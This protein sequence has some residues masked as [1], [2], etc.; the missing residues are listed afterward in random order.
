MVGKIATETELYQP[1]HDFMTALGYEVHGEV[2]GCDLTA[3][4]EGELVIIELK[5]SINLDLLIQ[6][7]KRQ[8]LTDE[9]YIAVPKPKRSPFSKYW[10]DRC[11]LVRRL[12][13][14]LITV[15][16]R[17]E[18]PQVEVE[19]F[20]A[21]FNRQ[22]SKQASKRKL[23]SLKTELEGRH[24]NF[25]LGGSSRKKLMTA[26]KEN[27][28]HIA[29]CLQKYGTLSPKELRTL[30]TGPKTASIL[31]KNFYHWFD[32]VAYG[33]YQLSTE[34]EAAL[35][36]FSQLAIYYDGLLNKQDFETSRPEELVAKTDSSG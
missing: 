9:V 10:K 2:Q 12:E 5:R 6:A 4:K 33:S 18:P 1:I 17:A 14:G 20:P 24:G 32:R 31:Q 34:G 13:L 28:I 26:Y 19:I 7:V 21:P 22:K 3:S 16:F 25:N 8:R 23:K 27:A 35:K 15:S 11:L 36:E 30:G 29:C